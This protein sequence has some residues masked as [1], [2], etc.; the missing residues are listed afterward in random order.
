MVIRTVKEEMGWSFNLLAATTNRIYAILKLCLNLWST[1]WLNPSLIL[2]KNFNP[3]L[4]STLNTW[5]GSGL[6]NFIITLLKTLQEAGLRILTSS[7]FH[8]S[9][10]A[11]K[12][13][14][15]KK[16]VFVL[17]KGIWLFSTLL[18]YRGCYFLKLIEIDKHVIVL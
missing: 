15:L 1:K 6:A 8:C 12:K 7:L 4:Q 16:F 17:R 5:L 9:I 10:T 11:G 18:V 2:V 14:I 3:S 13:E